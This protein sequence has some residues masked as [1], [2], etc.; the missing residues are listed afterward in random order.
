[1]R[2][3]FERQTASPEQTAALA[4]GLAGVL[5][6][7]DVVALWGELGAGKTTF[8]RALCDAM[9]VGD[10][11]VASPTFVFVHVYPIAT[12][13][14]GAVSRAGGHERE[15][16]IGR[17]THV[18]AYRVTSPED[19]EALGWDRLFGSGGR[20]LGDS[21]AL[22]EWPQKLGAALP[23]ERADVELLATGEASRRVAF[24]LPETWGERPNAALLAQRDT[25]LCPTTRR[26]VSPT[27]ATYPFADE[28]ARQADLFG[29]LAEKYTLG[30]KVKPEEEGEA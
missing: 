2:V 24:T 1:L 28:R 13:V 29:W 26:W 8:V 20:A 27:S 30:R 17:I 12:P 10:G 22:I 6:A 5:R 18:D 9:G 19:L 14:A 25:V 23:S 3:R 7:G 15:H 4:Q 21:V 16:E 11:L